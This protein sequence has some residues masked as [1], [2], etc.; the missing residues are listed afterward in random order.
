MRC[1]GVADMRQLARKILVSP[2]FIM[3]CDG[4]RE[5]DFVQKDKDRRFYAT[6]SPVGVIKKVTRILKHN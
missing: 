3:L 1:M 5:I 4:K 2:S 6:C